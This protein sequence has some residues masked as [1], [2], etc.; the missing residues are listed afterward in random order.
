MAVLKIALM[1]H[2]VLRRIAT[3]VTD[4]ATP[5]VRRLIADMSDTMHDAPGVGLAA[6]QVLEGL[7]AIVFR[8]PA[9]RQDGGEDEVPDTVLLNPEIEPL[10]DRRVLGWEGCLSVPGLRGLVPRWSRIGYRGLLPDGRKIEQEASGFLAR[11]I[12][13]ECDH[14]DGILYID[15]MPDLRLLVCDDAA[16]EFRLADY[17]DREPAAGPL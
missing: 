16:D 15:R 17:V 7:R 6:P 3:P 10:T 8:V 9:E 4:L 11:V 1:G 12:Q 14:L 13:H 5:E 2:P